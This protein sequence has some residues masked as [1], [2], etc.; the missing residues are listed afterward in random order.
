MEISFL[1]ALV[2]VKGTDLTEVLGEVFLAFYAR[3]GLWLFLATS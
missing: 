3:L 2:I 1:R